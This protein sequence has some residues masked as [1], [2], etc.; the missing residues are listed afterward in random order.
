MILSNPT[1]RSASLLVF[2]TCSLVA[3]LQPLHA[4]AEKV[5]ASRGE[6]AEAILQRL[7]ISQT[8][9][10]QK[11]KGNLRVGSRKAPFVLDLNG[12]VSTYTFLDT[13]ESLRLS[14]GADSSTIEEIDA[15]GKV[16]QVGRRLFD[17]KVAG[18]PLT[19]EDVALRFLYWPHAEVVGEETI[20]TIKCW[21]LWVATPPKDSQYAGVYIWVGKNGALMRADCYA[22]G[23]RLAK[24]FKVISGQ[25]ID[26]QW[27]L[28][29][30][31]I[32][33]YDPPGSKKPVMAYLNID[34]KME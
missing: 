3:P 23:S 33:S 10:N 26:G 16:K 14:L 21:K 1:L 13:G 18:T 9:Q 15:Q 31:R 11:L 32:E 7:R 20:N 29:S 27:V 12:P 2:L 17:E 28:K 34:G 24:T 30:M 22:S 6:E 8:L 5:E 19:Y 25:E 4:Q